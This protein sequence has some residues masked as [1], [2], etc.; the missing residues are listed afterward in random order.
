MK[1]QQRSRT[2]LMGMSDVDVEVVVYGVELSS[3]Q[4]TSI[5]KVVAGNQPV[6]SGDFPDQTTKHKV[7]EQHPCDSSFCEKNP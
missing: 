5:R 2:Y 6:D 3:R 7:Q 4:V 1:E